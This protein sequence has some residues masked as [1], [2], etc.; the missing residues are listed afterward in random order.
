M[1]RGRDMLDASLV[2]VAALL[3][4]GIVAILMS[5]AAYVWNIVL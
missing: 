5:L 1:I 2:V 3:W 4:V